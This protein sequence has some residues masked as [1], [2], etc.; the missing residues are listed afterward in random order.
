MFN[1]NKIVKV[2]EC[3]LL[4]DPDHL[5]DSC[6]EISPVVRFVVTE[7]I[8]LIL[9]TENDYITLGFDGVRRY[10]ELPFDL[11]KYNIEDVDFH[12]PDSDRIIPDVKTLLFVG[13][14]LCNVFEYTDNHFELEFDDFTLYLY[15][16]IIDKHPFFWKP[17]NSIDVPI[18]GFERHITR[19]CECGA[20]PELML[21][22]VFDYYLRCPKCHHATWD[23]FDLETVI[24][25]WNSGN[26]PRIQDTLQSDDSLFMKYANE[27]VHYIML[28]ERPWFWNTN[29]CDC[30]Y[31][32]VAIGDEVFKIE[33][34]YIGVE[35]EDFRYEHIS[36]LTSK[37]YRKIIS[38]EE[39]PLRFIRREQKPECSPV[40][41][42]QLGERPLLITAMDTE[43]GVGLSHWDINGK[44]IEYEDNQLLNDGGEPIDA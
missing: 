18:H 40:L 30:D 15:P 12:V 16:R 36:G 24:N 34:Q 43:V 26:T 6:F 4:D 13:E 1:P 29:V 20:E 27:P 28:D 22:S 39:E 3:S 33:S 7:K 11:E 17:C 35:E 41:R 38:T 8:Y 23:T 5:Y 42:F 21:D 2:M 44:W 9:Q 25:D 37:S 10:E 14:K 31:V 32:F 19:K